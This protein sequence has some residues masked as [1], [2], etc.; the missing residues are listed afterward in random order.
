MQLFSTV[1]FRVVPNSSTMAL[2]TCAYQRG[3]QRCRLQAVEVQLQPKL[4]TILLL[5]N[6]SM[7]WLLS[8]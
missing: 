7:A 6:D 1:L 5:S 8:S 3:S 2:N 4:V